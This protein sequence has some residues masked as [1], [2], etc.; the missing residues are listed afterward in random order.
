MNYIYKNITTKEEVEDC[1]AEEYALNEL[2]ITVTPKGPNG[3]MTQEQLNNIKETV[4]WFFS[5]NWV[6]EVV[7]N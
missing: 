7:E 1:M 5:G 3:T 4:E 6:K 2:G